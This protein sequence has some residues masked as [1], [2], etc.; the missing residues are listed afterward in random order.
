MNLL[1]MGARVYNLD[2]NGAYWDH[3]T[4]ADSTSYHAL[5]GGGSFQVFTITDVG[6]A[7][8]TSLQAA[9]VTL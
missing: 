3:N 4:T 5:G 8:F 2:S 7:W 6:G 9:A 1:N